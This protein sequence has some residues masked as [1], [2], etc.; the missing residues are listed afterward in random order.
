MKERKIEKGR[1]RHHELCEQ[2]TLYVTNGKPSTV[3][4]SALRHIFSLYKHYDSSETQLGVTFAKRLWYRSGLKLKY[5]DRII[6]E[7]VLKTNAICANAIIV[8][9]DYFKVICSIVAE[10]ELFYNEFFNSNSGDKWKSPD[11]DHF[12]VSSFPCARVQL[13]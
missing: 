7:K 12:E 4:E 5:L 8:F 10:D 11:D 2:R 1:A 6:E 13:T 9:D 3:L